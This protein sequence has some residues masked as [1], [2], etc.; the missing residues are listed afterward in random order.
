MHSSMTE[1]PQCPWVVDVF[2]YFQLLQVVEG[3]GGKGVPSKATLLFAQWW[4]L[5][6]SCVTFQRHL[7]Q[8]NL[9]LIYGFKV[10]AEATSKVAGVGEL[11][12]V[13][14]LLALY[15]H[16]VLG[17]G[18]W[19]VTGKRWWRGPA[20]HRVSVMECSSWQG[21]SWVRAITASLLP[22]D[23]RH[24]V[25]WSREGLGLRV[26][27]GHWNTS[28]QTQELKKKNG[29]ERGQGNMSKAWSEGWKRLKESSHISS[30]PR[31]KLH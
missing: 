5:S 29:T 19:N 6:S 25:F 9:W 8:K 17:Q 1:T 23:P 30:G 16:H 22:Q 31:H 4:L 12:C 10:F 21:S 27:A 11:S 28:E 20:S 26:K 24:I 7:R 3:H 14:S 2:P 13:K 18:P 15:F